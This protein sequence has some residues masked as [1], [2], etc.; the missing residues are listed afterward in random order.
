MEAIHPREEVETREEYTRRV[1]IAV[2]IVV[3]TV[4]VGTVFVLISDVFFLFYAAILLAILLRA[5]VNFLSRQTGMSSNLALAVVLILIAIVLAAAGYFFG[6]MAV[7]QWN[8]LTDQIPRSLD[9]LRERMHSSAWGQSLLSRLPSGQDIMSLGSGSMAG[10]VASFFTTTLGILGN[11]FVL[12][13]LAIYLAAA[14]G[15]YREGVVRLVPPARRS[16]AREVLITTGEKLKYWL[17]GR[18]VS[19]ATVGTIVG[20]GLAII[21]VPQF[22]ILG[23][24]AGLLSAIPFLG[25]IL[26]A[27]PG[28]LIALMHGGDVA[29]WALLVYALSQCVE[30]Y[31]VTPLVQ[32]RMVSM[33]PVVTIASITVIGT[34]FG[35]LGMIVASPL[36]VAIQTLIQTLYVEDVLGDET[37][38]DDESA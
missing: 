29:L 7:S 12:T 34:L 15:M 19:M 13:F 32:E 1:V 4:A 6:T 36:A 24:L 3:L 17:L 22:L 30:N 2:G 33:S 23:L 38:T 20:V 16:R 10:R 35:V 37:E 9:H 8:Q 18:L 26:G 31:L 11:L 27:I 21:G 25:P 28:L 14:P 5:G